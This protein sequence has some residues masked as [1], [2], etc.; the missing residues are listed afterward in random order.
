MRPPSCCSFVGRER[1][2]HRRAGDGGGAEQKKGW[3]REKERAA[4][5]EEEERA[6]GEGLSY[7][8]VRV[9]AG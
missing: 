5:G 8:G 6:V 4:A 1:G 2:Q 3:G 9:R 7:C